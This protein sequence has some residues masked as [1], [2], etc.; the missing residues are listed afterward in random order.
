MATAIVR[1]ADEP[2]PDSANPILTIVIVNWRVR[3]MLRDCLRSI[4][5]EGGLP[6]VSLQIIVVDNASEDGTTEMMHGEFP[7][8]QYI[9]SEINLGFGRA[10]MLAWPYAR[11]PL[12]LLL[13]PD[14]LIQGGALAA[15]VD[16]IQQRPD[17]WALGCRLL[18][19]D[20]SLQR[21]T[22]GRFPTLWNVGSHYLGLGRLLGPMGFDHSLYLTR[23]AGNDRVVDWV[24]GA[25]I[26]LRRDRTPEPLFDPSYFMY[27]EDMDLC[28]RIQRAGG[29]ILYSPVASVVHFQ[30]ASMEQ[31]TGEVLLTSLKGVRSFYARRAGPLHTHVFD[32]L[33]V[34]GFALR[35]FAFSGAALLRPRGPWTLKARS[36]LHHLRLAL[37]LMWA[38]PG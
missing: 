1:P 24:S 25:S 31:Q 20:G 23:D 36:S 15:M 37:T 12:V 7:T 18:N 5:E 14:T 19:R 21:W 13:N 22:G 17:V 4:A 33:T 26:M 38:A 34:A 2:N 16:R 11:A 29:R 27:G 32:V 10:N 3:E 30:G 28:W 9:A 6:A 8:I 35:W